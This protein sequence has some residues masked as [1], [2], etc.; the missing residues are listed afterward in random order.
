MSELAFARLPDTHHLVSRS[1]EIPTAYV[2]GLKKRRPD[3]PESSRLPDPHHLACRS[4]E[5][6]AA[7]VQ[8]LKKKALWCTRGE[9]RIEARAAAC[10]AA[11]RA[12]GPELV[13]Q[14]DAA[15]IERLRGR[16]A[17]CK[18]GCGA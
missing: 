10:G 12:P 2:Q 13:R 8:G 5:I 9:R 4:S 3:A 15:S 14:R 7:Y 16:Q 17:H 18:R 6:P 11:W 1:S